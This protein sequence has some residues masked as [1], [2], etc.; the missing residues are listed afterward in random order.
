MTVCHAV[1]L[2]HRKNATG[3]D[4][5]LSCARAGMKNDE[6]TC[7]LHNGVTNGVISSNRIKKLIFEMVKCCV[8][9]AVRTEFLNDNYMSFGFKSIATPPTFFG[10][11]GLEVFTKMYV[12]VNDFLYLTL[13]SSMNMNICSTF[14]ENKSIVL[15]LNVNI[16]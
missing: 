1:C 7:I 10:I 12:S 5:P 3:I 4:G 9:F 13:R 15:N 14:S 11:K 16:I 6:K 2:V 8:F